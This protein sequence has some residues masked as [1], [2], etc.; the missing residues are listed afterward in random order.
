MQCDFFVTAVLV[1][2]NLIVMS[3]LII[4]FIWCWK[5]PNVTSIWLRR[6]LTMRILKVLYRLFWAHLQRNVK[7]CYH[8]THIYMLM[9][10]K[11]LNSWLWEYKKL[12]R[13]RNFCFRTI[14]GEMIS[15]FVM[16]MAT[17][18][19]DLTTYAECAKLWIIIAWIRRSIIW[20]VWCRILILI[21]YVNIEYYDNRFFI[22][23]LF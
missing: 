17:S 12:A 15:K 23:K 20:L 4:Y 13:M 7:L 5:I 9:T 19:H 11:Q 2:S 3:Y 8:H 1:T 22:N 21:H 10:L 14:F 16:N 18:A 6:F